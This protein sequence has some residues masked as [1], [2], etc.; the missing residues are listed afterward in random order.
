MLYPK[1]TEYLEALRRDTG[2]LLIPELSGARIS[3]GLMGL[4]KYYSGAFAIVVPLRS[5]KKNKAVRMYTMHIEDVEQSYRVIRDYLQGVR[6]SYFVDFTYYAEGI[7]I[8]QQRYPVLVMD[9]LTGQTLKPFI[10]DNLHDEHRL[11]RLA[12]SWREMALSLRSSAIAHGDLQEANIFIE[13]AGFEFSLRL[14]DYDSLVIPALVG[15]KENILGVPAYQHP[16]REKSNIKSL[17][18]DIFSAFVIDFF[19]RVLSQYP[20]L[21]Y[22]WNIDDL[23]SALLLEAEDYNV[24]HRSEKIRHLMT[25]STEIRNATEQLCFL[26]EQTHF[27]SL[28]SLSELWSPNATPT[29]SAIAVTSVQPPRSVQIQDTE[30]P[31]YA[32]LQTPP[33]ATNT[34]QIAKA[35][36][37][38]QKQIE[39]NAGEQRVFRV[40]GA[41]FA[42]RW[43]PA[44]RFFMGAGADDR[45]ASNSEKPQHE[46]SITRGFW[47]AETPV[48]QG[49]YQTIMSNNPSYFKDAGLDAPVECVSWFD[50]AAFANKLS[51]LEGL[52]ACFAGSGEKMGGVGSGGSNY[53]RCK[54]WRLLTEAEWEYACRAGTVTPRYGEL[55]QIARYDENSGNTTRRVGRKQANA[56]GLYDTLGNVWE[57]CYDLCGP[58]PRQATDPIGADTGT[59]RVLRGGSWV[60]SAYFVRAA[61]RYRTAPTRRSSDIGFRVVR[62]AL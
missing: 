21:W 20:G 26:C 62:R 51:A 50:A 61:C 32:K 57:W 4:P 12:Y 24:P 22:T 38:E 7:L 40:G 33:A 30:R 18:V 53:V 27:S 49:Q 31:W 13:Q 10:K 48:T 43:I 47:I 60:N 28:P 8:Q 52:S 11:L 35:E 39:P 58:Y 1:R 29:T 59:D 15:K 25:L 45:A 37:Q 44:G 19:I 36:S 54:G 2:C 34:P 41:D 46:V 6:R 42:M 23:D 9:W 14:L 3:P 56:W 17:D 16:S 5:E 55:E